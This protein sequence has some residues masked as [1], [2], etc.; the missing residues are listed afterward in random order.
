MDIKEQTTENLDK[1]ISLVKD[2]NV[3]LATH[4]D[5][6]GVTSGALL[7]HLIKD[8]AKSIATLSKGDVFLVTP[9]DIEQNTKENMPDIIIC[10]DIRPSPDLI[11]MKNEPFVI[12]ID[13]HPNEEEINLYPFSIYDTDAKSCSLLIWKELIPKTSNPYFIFLTLLGYFGDGG[14]KEELPESLLKKA[15]E[16]IP[17]LIKEKPSRFNNSTYWEIE[18]FVSGMNVGKRVF[19]SGELPLEL[20]KDISHYDSFIYNKHPIASELMDIKQ[21]L[22]QLYSMNLDF[23]ELDKLKYA[24]IES[25]KNIQ[26]VLCA[27]HMQNKPILVMNKINSKVMGSMRSPSGMDFDAGEFLSQFNSSI[28]TY[29]GGGH[30]EAG[31]F[32]LDES[33]FDEFLNML[34]QDDA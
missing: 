12:S 22:R 29:Q 4:W 2:K 24:I 3:F 13:H 21:E 34:K 26:G 33:H 23:H 30:K 15:K 31:G 32:T 19:W 20:L 8:H 6:D 16:I 7:Y 9:E 10:T 14:L 28:E 17:E 5:C 27:K 18:R 11:T 25:D 1:L